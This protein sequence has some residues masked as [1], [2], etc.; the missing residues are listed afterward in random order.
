MPEAYR[1]GEVS[2]V[3]QVQGVTA[4]RFHQEIVPAG[5][6]VVLRGLVRSWP[7]VAAAEESG[8]A[9]GAYLGRF[10]RDRPLGAMV[11]PPKIKGR[12]FYNDEL[13]GFNFRRQSVKLTGAF[14]FLLRAAEEAEPPAFAI[15][16]AQVWNN[17]PGFEAE[18]PMHLLG[19]EVEPRVWIG[20]RVIVAAHHDPSEN[21]ACVVAGRRRFTLFPP[22]QIA[23]LYMG[24]M[25][26]TPAGTVVSMVDF[27]HPDLEAHPG[28]A[29]AMEAALVA[30]L[31]PGDALF[32]PC[33]WWHH[34]RS[35]D[36]IN[37]L[38]NYW[39]GPAKADK[40]HPMDAMFHAMLTIRELPEAHRAAWRAHFDHYVFGGGGA[41][42]HLPS[43]RQGVLGPLDEKLRTELKDAIQR[44]LTR[45]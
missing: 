6:P 35:L 11:G 39:W 22:E 12:F 26:K 4:E 13:T 34:V 32:I 16:S 31:E 42:A 2:A 43:A 36:S 28:F 33:M 3:D 27:D 38:V 25:E 9:L 14:E 41:G 7:V 44:G 23:N 40:S 15:Q 37:M 30:D 18:N 24:P 19:P 8:T 20:N 5:R 21:I 45:G 29:E 1:H 10:D 17:L